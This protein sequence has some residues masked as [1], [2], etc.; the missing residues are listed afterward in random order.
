MFE[1]LLFK[2]GARMVTHISFQNQ[3]TEKYTLLAKYKTV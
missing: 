1:Y 3:W 2:F